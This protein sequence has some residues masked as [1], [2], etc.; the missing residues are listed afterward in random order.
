MYVYR[1]RTY[2]MIRNPRALDWRELLVVN[3][4]LVVNRVN[5]Y[6]IIIIM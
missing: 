4:I 3:E 5:M 1:L 6:I 2:N